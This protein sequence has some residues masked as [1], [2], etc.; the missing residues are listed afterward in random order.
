MTSTYLTILKNILITVEYLHHLLRTYFICKILKTGTSLQVQWLKLCASN[1]GDL[2]LISGWG[3]KIP[4]A[5]WHSQGKKKKEKKKER[6]KKR[7]PV[8]RTC[9]D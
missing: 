4:H 1:A 2:C 9:E 6:E 3:T 5:W 7:M 8:C